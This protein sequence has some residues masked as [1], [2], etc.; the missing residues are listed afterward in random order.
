[1]VAPLKAEDK[2]KFQKLARS[3]GLLYFIPKKR[4]ENNPVFNVVSNEANAAKLNAV[5]QAMG[6]PVPARENQEEPAKK[7]IPRA[8][9]ERSSPGRG[10]GSKQTMERPTNKP[11]VKRRLEAMRAASESMK[12]GPVKNREHIR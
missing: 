12:S 8:P 1:M 3:F 5:F 2:K 10:N 4:G 9:Q 6:Y 7:A 11:S